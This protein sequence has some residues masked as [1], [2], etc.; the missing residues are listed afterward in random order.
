MFPDKLFPGDRHS[1]GISNRDGTV[2][3]LEQGMAEIDL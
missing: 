2:H 1:P 3:L